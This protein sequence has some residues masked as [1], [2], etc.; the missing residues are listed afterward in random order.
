MEDKKKEPLKFYGSGFSKEPL[1]DEELAAQRERNR[2]Y[3]HH[4]LSVDEFLEMAG[5]SWLAMIGAMTKNWKALGAMGAI[6][7]Y[8]GG[9]NFIQGVTAFMRGFL[10]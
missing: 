1:T 9:E 7:I 8:F 10:P 2:H 5:L 3:D 6:A 4:F